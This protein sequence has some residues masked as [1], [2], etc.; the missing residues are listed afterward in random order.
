[1]ISPCARR[2]VRHGGLDRASRLGREELGG[3][4]DHEEAVGHP[5][6]GGGAVDLARH[7]QLVGRRCGDARRG[8]DAEC[9]GSVVGRQDH[10][11]ITEAH[12][13]RGQSEQESAVDH[14]DQPAPEV[15]HAL[16]GGRNVREGDDLHR[17]DDLDD[18]RQSEGTPRRADLDDQ[19]VG[20]VA[21]RGRRTMFTSIEADGDRSVCL[22]RCG[23]R[24]TRRRA[25]DHH[26]PQDHLYVVRVPKRSPV[27]EVLARCGRPVGKVDAR[28]RL[29]QE[30]CALFYRHGI[31]AVG[32]D[33]LITRS[34]IAKATFYRH[35]PSKLDLVLA[36]VDR[37][38]DAFLDWLSD[39]VNARVSARSCAPSPAAPLL[40]VFDAAGELFADPAYRG[41]PVTNAVA[42]LGDEGKVVLDRARAHKAAL[43][44]FVLDLAETAGVE[45]P[46]EVADTWVLLLDGAIVAG[47]R[48]RSRKPA[49]AARRAA[50]RYLEV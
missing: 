7:R 38:H 46:R 29:V 16:D 35:F 8:V 47:H 25:A 34:G 42:E 15:D 21:H 10:E 11:P 9:P 32:I 1:M 39:E 41:C 2:H 17:G 40:A 23:L 48:E 27:A 5:R 18:I 33:L 49:A 43:R 19:H 44:A 24:S 26:Q 36:Y 20:R 13:R 4:E 31:R 30:A 50:E 37:R 22:H 6:Q 12:R 28:E 45:R 3:I 14:R